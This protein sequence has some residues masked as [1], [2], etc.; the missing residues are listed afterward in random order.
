MKIKNIYEK[1]VPIKS[2]MRNA[3]I[4]FSAM[5]IS[6]IAIES[7]VVRNGKPIIGYG[8]NSNG[9]YAQHGIL[10]DRIIPRMQQANSKDIINENGD[11]FDPFKCWDIM[12]KNEKPGGHGERSVAIGTVDMALWD[13]VAKIE[14]QPLCQLL[15]QRFRSKPADES[16]YVYAAGGYYNPGK[17]LQ[18]LQDELKKYIDMGFSACKIKIGGAALAEDVRRIEAAIEVLGTGDK[19]AVDANGGFD[20]RTALNYAEAIEPYNLKWYEEPGDP[21]DFQLN[22][23]IAEVSKTPIA[24]GENIFSFID[25]QNLVRHG[26]MF[27]NRDYLQMDPVLGYGLVEYLRILDMLSKHGWSPKRCI[28]H[29]GHQFGLHLAAGLGLYGNEAYPDVFYPFG[30]FADNIIQTDGRVVLPDAPGIGYET[31]PEIFDVLK[32]LHD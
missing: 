23:A 19:L 4:D 5:T 32:S 8:F 6:I 14:E 28:P 7:D 11:N 24:T 16:V 25:S 22:A 30:K 9:R 12:F 2:Q 29:G 20:L 3:V 21:L 31:V 15:S 13:L 17:N 1:T 27:P 26:G 18:L 10:N